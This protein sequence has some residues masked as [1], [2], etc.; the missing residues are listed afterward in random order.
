MENLPNYSF[1]KKKELLGQIEDEVI[2]LT[3]SYLRLS[4]QLFAIYID[5]FIFYECFY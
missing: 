4:S 1:E 5:F 2:N 3:K